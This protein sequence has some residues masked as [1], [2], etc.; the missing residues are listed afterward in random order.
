METLALLLSTSA[1][2][3]TTGGVHVPL[4]LGG[5]F[6]L[7][8]AVRFMWRSVGPVLAILKAALYAVSSFFLIAVVVVLLVVAAVSN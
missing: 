6:I 8:L 7:L 4:V 1:T 2:P 5:A 3:A